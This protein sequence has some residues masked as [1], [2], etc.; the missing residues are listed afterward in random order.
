MCIRDSKSAVRPVWQSRIYDGAEFA[1]ARQPLAQV[2]EPTD[3]GTAD[4][5][6]LI[7]NHFKSKGSAPAA[8]TDPANEDSG[9]GAWNALRTEQ[10]KGLV[11]FAESVKQSTGV[12]KVLLDGDFNSYGFEDPLEVLKSAGYVSLEKKYDA[13]STYVFDGMVGSLDHAF[14]N[15]AALGSVTGAAVWN[16]NAGEAVAHEYSRY[17]YNVTNVFDPTTPYRCSDHDPIV[18]GMKVTGRAAPAEL[19]TTLTPAKVVVGQ[20][21]ARVRVEVTSNGASVSGGAVDIA[22]GD[23]VLGSAQVVDGVATVTLPAFGSV[24][25]QRLTATYS[26][27][28]P[29]G[30]RHFA[31]DVVKATP[32][33]SVTH[34][35]TIRAKRTNPWVLV[36][37]AAPGQS[38]T[39]TVS[40]RANGRTWVKALSGQ[41]ARFNLGR[42]ATPGSKR[43]VIR[44]LGSN[45]ATPVSRVVTLR[46]VR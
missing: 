22:D 26:G 14:A 37:M 19:K 34:T 15:P 45:R 4:R 9:Q 41:R 31:I 12:D 24:G 1:K 35:R 42:F 32:R 44:Y 33:M 27:S 16:I 7:V 11:R 46:V 3:G 23:R 2:F 6:I 28:V 20:T 13:G 39:G 40:V 18:F 29:D 5:F 43:V 10:A 36:S 25:V 17:N 38:V 21:R 8:G 30:V